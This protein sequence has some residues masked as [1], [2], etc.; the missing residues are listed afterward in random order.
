[1][2]NG[3][4]FFRE[5]D[6]YELVIIWIM[7]EGGQAKGPRFFLPRINNGGLRFIR[8][9]RKL[10]IQTALTTANYFDRV[11][12]RL[13]L[14]SIQH[15]F[16]SNNVNLIKITSFCRFRRFYQKIFLFRNNNNLGFRS[17]LFDKGSYLMFVRVLIFRINYFLIAVLRKL[18]VSV[19]IEIKR[20]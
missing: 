5:K 8:L 3:K 17:S 13:I 11:T 6:F 15:S 20:L 7:E 4:E 9:P 19:V 12:L 14:H 1:M 16:H 18:F 2:D 10:T